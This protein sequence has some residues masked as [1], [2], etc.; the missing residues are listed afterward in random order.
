MAVPT[1]QG[2]SVGLRQDD[3][4]VIGGGKVVYVGPSY[5]TSLHHETEVRQW[6]A[7]I[8]VCVLHAWGCRA[9]R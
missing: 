3:R 6:S 1:L 2:I 9:G 7:L 5:G 4:T 8:G